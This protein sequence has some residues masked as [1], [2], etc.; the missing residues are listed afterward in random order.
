MKRHGGLIAVLTVLSL[1]GCATQRGV[2]GDPGRLTEQHVVGLSALEP[3][4]G[5]VALGPVIAD[6][7]GNIRIESVFPRLIDEAIRLGANFVVVDHLYTWFEWR[8]QTVTSSYACGPH[9][10]MCSSTSTVP[11]EVSLMRMT[12]RAYRAEGRR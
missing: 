3:P 12:G 6:A 8:M 7:V 2:H 5:A 9:G 4:P 11:V 1:A 10:A